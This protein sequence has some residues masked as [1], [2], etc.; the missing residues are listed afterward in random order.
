VRALSIGRLLPTIHYYPSPIDPRLP[1][2]LRGRARA[3][4]MRSRRRVLSLVVPSHVGRDWAASAPPPRYPR[5]LQPL[6]SSAAPRRFRVWARWAGPSWLAPPGREQAA[7]CKPLPLPPPGTARCTSQM[8]GGY[9]SP[10]PAPSPSAERARSSPSL[11][12]LLP[13]DAGL[14][15]SGPGCA[16]L[17]L[18]LKP[19][20]DATPLGFR[21]DEASRCRLTWRRLP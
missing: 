2:L 9:S 14:L 17:R 8:S 1:L 20:R 6:P 4:C 19:G 15:P 3:F 18:L 10:F 12:R 21:G 13:C 11:P 16:L 5:L 7:R